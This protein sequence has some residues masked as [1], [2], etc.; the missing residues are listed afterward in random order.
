MLAVD[1]ID[2]TKITN[3]RTALFATSTNFLSDSEVSAGIELGN[4]N[5]KWFPL[6]AAISHTLVGYLR[7]L[8]INGSMYPKLEHYGGLNGKQ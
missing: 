5:R 1:W 7:D 3:S 4:I 2:L 6:A 8:L